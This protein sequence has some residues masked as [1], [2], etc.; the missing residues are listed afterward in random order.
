MTSTDLIAGDRDFRVVYIDHYHM[1]PD[2]RRDSV[3]FLC[4]PGYRGEGIYSFGNAGLHPMDLRR[5]VRGPDDRPDLAQSTSR[6]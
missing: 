2:I 1:S 4:D 6:L 3:V 5:V